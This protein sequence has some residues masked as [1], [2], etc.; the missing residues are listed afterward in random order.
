MKPGAPAGRP[1][2]L[3]EDI[4]VSF[5]RVT[6]LAGLSLSAKHGE[7]LGIIGPNGSG[8]TTLLN[9]IAGTLRPS[10]GRIALDGREISGLNPRTISKLGVARTHQTPRPFLGLSVME[11]TLARACFGNHEAPLPED[12]VGEAMEALRLAGLEAKEGVFAS[13]LTAAEQTR[14][15]LAGAWVVKPR[16]LLLDEI[17]SGLA[18]GD[19]EKMIGLV[20]EFRQV[21]TTIVMVEHSLRVVAR[22]CDRVVA[23]NGGALIAQGRPEE[24]VTA[25]SVMAAF[26]GRDG[27]S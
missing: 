7:V 12:C 8:K 9:T 6:A 15:E 26:L 13:A 3:C 21:G 11:N 16:L 23:L 17:G 2:L 27:S 5:P 14:L 20:E 10:S 22:L 1:L 4:R 19:R 18:Y 24:V 25:P